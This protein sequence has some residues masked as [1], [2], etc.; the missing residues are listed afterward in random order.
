MI[1]ILG[2]SYAVTVGSDIQRDGMFLE[3][4]DGEKAALAEVF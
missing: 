2:Q 4:E 1:E 3:V